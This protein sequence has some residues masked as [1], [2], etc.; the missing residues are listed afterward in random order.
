MSVYEFQKLLTDAPVFRSTWEPASNV[1]ATASTTKTRIS[2]ASCEPAS[3]RTNA[4]MRVGVGFGEISA[5]KVHRYAPRDKNPGTERRARRMLCGR[6][7]QDT[8]AA[9]G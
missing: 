1:S 2:P 5:T 7:R 3:R 6:Q 9:R 8:R 4:R